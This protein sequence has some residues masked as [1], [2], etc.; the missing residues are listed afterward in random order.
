MLAEGAN[1]LIVAG[2]PHGETSDRT[3]LLSDRTHLPRSSHLIT[4][5]RA[6]R[7]RRMFNCP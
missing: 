4:H 2:E 6:R 5:T 1:G 3:E 7:A